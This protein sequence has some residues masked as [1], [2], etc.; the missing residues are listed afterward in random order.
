[1]EK[2]VGND[3]HYK[4]TSGRG[5]PFVGKLVRK[6]GIF[7]ELQNLRSGDVVR[8]SPGKV[9]KPYTFKPYNKGKDV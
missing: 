2:I 7:L 6:A 9:G 1:M 5:R 8:V 3:Y 4:T